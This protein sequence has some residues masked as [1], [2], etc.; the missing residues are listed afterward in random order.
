MLILVGKGYGD[1]PKYILEYLNQQKQKIDFVWLTS[2]SNNT[3]FPK[4]IRTVKIFSIKSFFELATAKVW[5]NNSRFDQF[6]I[7][8]KEQFYIQTWHGGLALKK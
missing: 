1:N 6:V 5:I 2:N 8:R 4:N 3:K 7:K